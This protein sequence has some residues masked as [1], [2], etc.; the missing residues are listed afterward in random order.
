[1]DSGAA[2]M[3]VSAQALAVNGGKAILSSGA[4]KG[5]EQEDPARY[6]SLHHPG[7]QY[8]L[9]MFAQIGQALRVPA[10]SVL[11]GLRPKHV[12]AVGESQSA[13]YLTTYA[14]AIQPPDPAYQGIFIHS[15]EVG[16]PRSMDR[17]DPRR[18]AGTFASA[19][20]SPSPSSCS[21]PR[22]T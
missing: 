8:S 15:A 2:Y 4:S 21:R 17:V 5:L 9:D 18:S 11:G 20:T 12:V 7:D 6:G 22:R 1:M 14:D 10:P 19:P 16:P 13:F 3:A